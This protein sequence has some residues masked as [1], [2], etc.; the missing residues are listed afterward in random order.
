MDDHDLTEQRIVLSENLEMENLPEPKLECEYMGL[1]YINPA[2]EIGD[3]N[4]YKFIK[5]RADIKRGELILVEHVFANNQSVCSLAIKY[6]EHLFDEYHPRAVKYRDALAMTN[7]KI[8]EIVHEK[9]AHN[10]FSLEKNLLL[11]NTITKMNHSCDP[12][13]AVYIQENYCTEDTPTIFMELYA[14]QNIPANT[15]ITISYGAKTSHERDFTCN[16][17]KSLEERQRHFGVVT[18]LANYFSNQ[19]NAEVK[20]LI[21][22]YLSLAT[23]KRIL[24][25]H[26]LATNGIFMDKSRVNVYTT[27]GGK[28]INDVVNAFM[29]LD[30]GKFNAAIREGPI[31]EA[32]ID[33]FMWILENKFLQ[34]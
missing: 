33:I 14:I 17:G 11:T 34:S 2:I 30:P 13:C 25:N 3:I 12:S 8:D 4:D 29:K 7:E 32:R 16:C 24:L 19:N 26:Y 15:E 21:N 27:D 10:C 18:Q 22:N 28:I 31:N 20:T 9:L 1:V 5:T 6:N 23:A